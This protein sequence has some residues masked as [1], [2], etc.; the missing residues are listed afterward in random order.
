MRR[1]VSLIPVKLALALVGT[2]SAAVAGDAVIGEGVFA[3]RC[4]GC[5]QAP[6]N[7]RTAGPSLAGVVRP[8]VIA[9]IRLL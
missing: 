1:Q 8:P 3:N 7:A 9:R 6:S 5:H 4:K 2:T